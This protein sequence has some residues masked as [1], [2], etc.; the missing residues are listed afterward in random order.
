MIVFADTVAPAWLNLT[1]TA[2]LLIALF[3]MVGSPDR[4]E[5]EKSAMPAAAPPLMV[6]PVIIAPGSRRTTGLLSH[7]HRSGSCA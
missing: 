1:P 4:T 6:L 7:S 5:P 3:V 2:R